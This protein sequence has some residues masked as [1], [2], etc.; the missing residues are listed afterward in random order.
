MAAEDYSPYQ[1]LKFQKNSFLR[2]QEIR[3][4]DFDPDYSNRPL[5]YKKPDSICSTPGEAL[6]LF[7][8]EKLE[9]S[10]EW[11]QQIS[12]YVHSFGLTLKITGDADIP[13][14]KDF[15]NQRYTPEM[16]NEICPFDLHRIRQYGHVLVLQDQN[17]KIKGTIFELGYDTAEKTSYTIR[18]AVD[19][20]HEGQNLGYHLMMYSTL[21]AMEQGSRVKRGLIQFA[22]T[23]SLYVN[24]NK[25]GWICDG[26]EPNIPGM[27]AFF[28][29][30]LPLDPTG[31]TGNRMDV[32]KIKDYMDQHVA[33]KDYMLIDLED[34]EGISSMYADTSFKVVALLPSGKNREKGS[35]FALPSEVLR[36]DTRYVPYR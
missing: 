7:W 31:L 29:I 6:P 13:L 15:L 24:L 35:F 36:L 1:F 33:E 11:R 26:F 14:I 8:R 4:H 12:H 10:K 25:V 5:L 16:A 34:L 19:Q 28:H 27:G 23:R 32:A 2:I 22:N 9:F 17:K 3:N 21:L 30:A 20:D 18:L